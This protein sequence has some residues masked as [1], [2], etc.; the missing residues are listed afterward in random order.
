V[1]S[2]DEDMRAQSIMAAC[3]RM[4]TSLEVDVNLSGE[5]TKMVE[6]L[7]ARVLQAVDDDTDKLFLARV[8]RQIPA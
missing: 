6:L 8:A 7:F 5:G 2:N 3:M 4:A 1:L